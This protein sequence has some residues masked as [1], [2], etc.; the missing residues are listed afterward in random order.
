M[1]TAGPHEGRTARSAEAERAQRR[2]SEPYATDGGCMSGFIESLES[3]NKNDTRG[4]ATRCGGAGLG[5]TA[6]REGRGGQAMSIG[7]ACAVHQSSTGST[8]TERRFIN[9]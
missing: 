7:K 1:D 6:G 9:L 5:A 8:S 3:R 4:R 2:D